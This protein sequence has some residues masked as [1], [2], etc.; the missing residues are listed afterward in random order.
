MKQVTRKVDLNKAAEAFEMIDAE[1]HLFYNTETGE[2]DW[3]NDFFGSPDDND[4][5]KFEDDEWVMAP[6][7]WDIEEYEMMVDFAG[8]VDDPRKCELLCVALE[9]RGA[10]R[11]F[12][13]TL[14]R[15]DMTEEWYKFKHEKYIE[16]AREWCEQNGL[17]YI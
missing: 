17:E 13:D 6:T 16:V 1:T 12:K 4:T 7:Q 15:V 3:Y 10:F 2:F 9:G 8:A 14:Y 5:E 11:R